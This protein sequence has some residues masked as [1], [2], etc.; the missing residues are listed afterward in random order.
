MN[1]CFEFLIFPNLLYNNTAMLSKDF[2][3]RNLDADTY[4]ENFLISA[5]VSI[6]VIRI[7]LKF[8]NYP[9]LGGG[10]LHIAHMLWGGFFMLIAIIVLLSFLNKGTLYFASILGG[11]G[12]GAFI[13]ELGK[14]ITR[15]NDYFF[16]PTIAYIYIVFVLLYIISRLIPRYQAISQK[17]YLVNSLEMIKESA[18]SDF[19]IEEEKRAREYLKK[20]DQRNYVVQSLI[21]LLSKIEASPIQRPNIYVRFRGFLRDKYYRVASSGFVLKFIIVFL[22]IQSLRTF[23]QSASLFAVKPNIPFYEWGQLLSSL[24]AGAFIVVGFLVMRFSRIEA[25][26]FF[27]ISMLVTILLTEVFAFMKLQWYELFG[28]AANLFILGVI[29]YAMAMERIK[30]KR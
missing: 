11:L 17:E 18:I 7:F 29:N 19:D 6:F 21:K 3:I 13:D 12:F 1:W 20:S 25:Y 30:S 24:L 5:I 22:A 14:F 27:R 26:R 28:L 8:T 10:D 23:L 4:R 16:Q 15:D 2:F 9:Q